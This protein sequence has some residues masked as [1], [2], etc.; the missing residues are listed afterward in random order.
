MKAKERALKDINQS[1]K[2]YK[3]NLDRWKI[4]QAELNPQSD[5]SDQPL[6]SYLDGCRSVTDSILRDLDYLSFLVSMIEER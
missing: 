2:R 4:K 6:Y 5:N 3:S 1:I